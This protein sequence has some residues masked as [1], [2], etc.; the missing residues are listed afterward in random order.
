M[1]HGA[2]SF[3]G[4]TLFEILTTQPVKSATLYN[5]PM[6]PIIDSCNNALV[7]GPSRK[8]SRNFEDGVNSKCCRRYFTL[9][10]DQK[11]GFSGLLGCDKEGLLNGD[12]LA[13]L[14]DF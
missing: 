2:F 8:K 14:D 13:F 6:Q 1:I 11:L 9:K 3:L 5:Q 10:I 7:S 4:E 12:T